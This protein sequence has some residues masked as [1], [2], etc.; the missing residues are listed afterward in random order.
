MTGIQFS[1]ARARSVSKILKDI[2]TENWLEIPKDYS[3][4]KEWGFKLSLLKFKEYLKDTKCND[5]YAVIL[6]LKQ[7]KSL[8][9]G[10]K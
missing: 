9:D 3:K 2:H 10:R 4:F 5:N 1:K 8:I 7:E 6:S